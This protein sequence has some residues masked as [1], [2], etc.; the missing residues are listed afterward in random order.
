MWSKSGTN[1]DPGEW[2]ML[3]VKHCG[4]VKNY[5]FAGYCAEPNV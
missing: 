5:E 4:S 2:G 1:Q 3:S